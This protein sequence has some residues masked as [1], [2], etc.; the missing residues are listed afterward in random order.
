MN[1]VSADAMRSHLS[2]L[3]SGVSTASSRLLV[4][5]ICPAS[6]RTAGIA[7]SMSFRRGLPI[8]SK[9]TK[10][11]RG[12]IEDWYRET[13]ARSRSFALQIYMGRTI[14]ARPAMS[15]AAATLALC[16]LLGISAPHLAEC[17]AGNKR[18][19][20]LSFLSKKSWHTGKRIN[21]DKVLQA[22]QEAQ[23]RH[24]E[25]EEQLDEDIRT[26]EV[27]GPS[28]FSADSVHRND[29]TF[30]RGGS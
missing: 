15:R 23:R 11:P 13:H 10:I 28:S 12:S 29:I 30:T 25:K 17:G 1:Q 20:S 21:K 26:A 19:S 5:F 22:E 18:G 24:R 14:V 4:P 9:E 8:T 16:W 6:E 3:N 7:A 2:L 27:F